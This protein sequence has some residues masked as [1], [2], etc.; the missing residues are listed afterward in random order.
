VFYFPGC[1][2]ERLFSDIA[3]A[4]IFLLF[5]SGF[6]VVL[7]PSHLCCGFPHRA[8]A[9]AEQSERIAIRNTMILSQLREMLG[10]L[11]FSACAVTCGTCREAL[12]ELDEIFRVPVED[13]ARIVLAR[14]PLRGS[15]TDTFY[16]APCHDSLSGEGASLVEAVMGKPSQ[17]IPHCC[18]QAGTLALS[19]PELAD[20]L[21]RRKASSVRELDPRRGVVPTVITNCPSCLQG[22]GRLTEPPVDARHFVVELAQIDGGP[23]WRSEA[24]TILGRAEPVTF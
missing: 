11:D 24:R 13:A 12:V 15:G 21:L 9:K 16:H 10:Y 3:L 14:R 4:A 6:Q 2:S 22:L 23:E 8:N 1:G 17:H 18:S 5:R 7:P 19:R 20:A